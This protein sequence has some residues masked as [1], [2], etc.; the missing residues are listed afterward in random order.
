[1]MLL[2]FIKRRHA[3]S[4]SSG[5]TTADAIPTPPQRPPQQP[6]TIEPVKSGDS[7]KPEAGGIKCDTE[8]LPK[9]TSKASQPEADKNANPPPQI[10][11]GT[12][13]LS[14]TDASMSQQPQHHYGYSPYSMSTQ[15]MYQQQSPYALQQ[16]STLPPATN[17]MTTQQQ[18]TT[19]QQ[20]N[21]SARDP[22]QQ[23]PNQ[24]PGGSPPGPANVILT[25]AVDGIDRLSDEII[26]GI[27]TQIAIELLGSEPH[28]NKGLFFFRKN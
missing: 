22:Q 6:I 4:N 5:G 28:N 12:P 27:A 18:Q 2:A 20:S 16:S 15:S 23:L 3:G 14:N 7:S 10:Q 11:T 17:M 25:T 24:T 19:A 13:I 9:P 26:R 1:M 21:P 8:M